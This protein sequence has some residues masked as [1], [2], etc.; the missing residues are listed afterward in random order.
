MSPYLSS[1]DCITHHII[2]R[3]LDPNHTYPLNREYVQPQWIFDCINMKMILPTHYYKP[4]QKLPPHLSPFVDD[5]K[6]GYIPK[7]KEEIQKLKINISTT[8]N[9]TNS[10][11]HELETIENDF[12]EDNNELNNAIKNYFRLTF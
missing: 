6:E 2:D 5:E 4:G 11:K 3:P 1:D 7:Y 8:S 9:S 12:D 10:T